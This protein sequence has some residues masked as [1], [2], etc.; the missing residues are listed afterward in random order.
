[1][2]VGGLTC[3]VIK[4]GEEFRFFGGGAVIGVHWVVPFF[5]VKSLVVIGA[6]FSHEGLW[7]RG[8]VLI[9][10]VHV[11]KRVKKYGRTNYPGPNS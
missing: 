1:M 4:S 7:I 8:L 11:R 10:N 5:W 3:W 6:A 9:E 2:L